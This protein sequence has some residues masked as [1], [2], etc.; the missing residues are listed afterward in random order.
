MRRAIERA[1][2]RVDALFLYGIQQLYPK[3]GF[4]SCFC[5]CEMKIDVRDAERAK[6]APGIRLLTHEDMEAFCALYNREHA[7]RSWTVVRQATGHHG[8]VR[9]TDWNPGEST[10]GFERGGELQGYAVI[11]AERFGEPEPLRASEIV[12][13]SAAAAEALV[14]E[15]GRR[16]VERRQASIVVCEPFDST[17]GRALRRLGATATL[18]SAADGGG[19]GVICRRR[20]LVE[21]LRPELERRA[22]CDQPEAVEALAGGGLYP[23]GM[24][25]R[26]LLGSHSWRD[27]LDLGHPLPEGRADLARAWFPGSGPVLPLPYTHPADRY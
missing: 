10:F 4:V 18:E 1:S 24:L 23:D 25:L 8:W 6:A 21:R 12:A 26:L 15:L 13:T 27:A 14:A 7:Q 16:A 17:V 20:A 2:E 11:T 19:M 9:A 5:E 22:G 3:F